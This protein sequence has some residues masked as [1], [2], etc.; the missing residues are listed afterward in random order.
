MAD[1][2]RLAGRPERQRGD[3]LLTSLHAAE[4]SAL[5]AHAL[6]DL[7]LAEPSLPADT[8]LCW[9]YSSLYAGLVDGLRFHPRRAH[10]RPHPC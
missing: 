3:G 7:L 2:D 9:A 4:M 8:A 6:G 5:E 10:S 1:T